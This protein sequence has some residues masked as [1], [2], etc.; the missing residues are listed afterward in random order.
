[1]HFCQPGLG[2]RGHESPHTKPG[3]VGRLPE[4]EHGACSTR[5][6]GLQ[7]SL[8]GVGQ[9]K[10]IPHSYAT[11]ASEDGPAA[12]PAKTSIVRLQSVKLSGQIKGSSGSWL[13]A[14]QGKSL[15]G[16]GCRL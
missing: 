3:R 6:G 7:A 15:P 10:R 9:R 4:R 14:G 12:R 8:R 5:R 2:V 16:K 13:G 11:R 1:M